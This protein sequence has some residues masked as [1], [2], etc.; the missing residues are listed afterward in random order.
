MRRCYHWTTYALM[1]KSSRSTAIIIKP[2]PLELKHRVNINWNGLTFIWMVPIMPTLFPKQITRNITNTDN[3]T[4]GIIEINF[5]RLIELKCFAVRWFFNSQRAQCILYNSRLFSW[6]AMDGWSFAHHEETV[7]L[8]SCFIILEIVLLVSF[9]IDSFM[10]NT[11]SSCGVCYHFQKRRGI[12]YSV[13]YA[14]K[15]GAR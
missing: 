7:A 15:V 8:C 11:G 3:D 12:L 10:N 13:G 14:W 6:F 4:A 5:L 9:H 2:T 1:M